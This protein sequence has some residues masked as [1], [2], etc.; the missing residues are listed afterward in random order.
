MVWKPV[1]VRVPKHLCELS[2]DYHQ[3]GETGSEHRCDPLHPSSLSVLHKCCPP[4]G[5]KGT[6]GPLRDLE[7]LSGLLKRTLFLKAFSLQGA[8][9]QLFQE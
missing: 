8:R 6:H 3:N 4:L 7:D 9:S 1:C 2:D 5:V